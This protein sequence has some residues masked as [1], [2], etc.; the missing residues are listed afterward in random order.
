MLSA[1]RDA[2]LD[3]DSGKLK[4]VVCESNDGF[5]AVVE[6]VFD[7]NCDREFNIQSEPLCINLNPDNNCLG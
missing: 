5:I 4:T 6:I 2:N 7:L 1:L 3:P